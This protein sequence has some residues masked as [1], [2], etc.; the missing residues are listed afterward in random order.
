MPTTISAAL[1]SDLPLMVDLLLQDASRKRGLNPTLWTIADDA[2]ETV[3]EAAKFALEAEKQPFLQ[4][5]LVAERDN[6]LMGLAHSMMLPVPPIYA[7]KWGDPGLL[8]PDSLV[9]EDAPTGTA[10]ALVEKPTFGTT[11]PS[12]C[13]RRPYRETRGDHASTGEAMSR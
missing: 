10:D 13:L 3:E 4:K 8:L 1:I 12:C 2:R 5:W 6:A 11:A 7:G 9:V